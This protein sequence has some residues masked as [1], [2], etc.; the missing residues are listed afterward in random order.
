MSSGYRFGVTG[1]AV[2]CGSSTGASSSY[3]ATRSS[4]VKPAFGNSTRPTCVQMRGVA[5]DATVQF[6][7][8]RKSS[9]RGAG[10]PVTIDSPHEVRR[11]RSGRK[12]LLLLFALAV[13]FFLARAALSYW[14]DLLWFGSLGYAPVFWTTLRLNIAVFAIGAVV[15]FALLYGGFTLLRRLYDELLPGEREILINGQPVNLPIGAAARILGLVI[16]ALASVIAGS[17]L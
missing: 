10:L 7:R 13:L 12:L 3:T 15:T 17:A 5:P 14:V 6:S 9:I 8:W 11:P 16:A 2:R 1:R 4:V